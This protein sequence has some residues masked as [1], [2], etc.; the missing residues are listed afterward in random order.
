M[1]FKVLRTIASRARVPFEELAFGLWSGQIPRIAWPERKVTRSFGLSV[2]F[3]DGGSEEQRGGTLSAKPPGWQRCLSIWA[4][5]LL[6]L[7]LF[8][9]LETVVC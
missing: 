3:A 8:L 7:V 9:S 1:F 4:P 5:L 6:L 2:G